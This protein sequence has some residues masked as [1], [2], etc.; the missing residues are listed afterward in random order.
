MFANRRRGNHRR[1]RSRREFSRCR[2]PLRP[3]PQSNVERRRRQVGRR[4]R[5]SL[6]FPL[7]H[8]QGEPRPPSVRATWYRLA[9]VGLGNGSGG[10]FDDQ[11]YVGV[12]TPWQWPDA[13]DGVTVSDLR[14]A[15]AAIA[16][17]R[18]REN[19][20]AKDWAG[21]AVAKAMGLDATNKAHRAKIPPC[22]GCG[23]RKE[24]WPSSRAWTPNARSGISSKWA[25]RPMTDFAAPAFRLSPCRAA[26]HT[27]IGG[28][29]AATGAP[30]LPH[31]A[32][33]HLCQVRQHRRRAKYRQTGQRSTMPLAGNNA[34]SSGP[35]LGLVSGRAAYFRA[36][37]SALGPHPGGDFRW[38]RR[39]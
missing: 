8:R 1:R 30:H 26:P 24:C 27:P 17:G 25:S 3:R 29:G 5:T 34:K 12:V 14:K 22:S 37:A 6:L 21:H 15:Q 36:R 7:R 23:S 13:F 32:V 28:G 20:Q 11:D 16:A 18:W 35:S 33:P 4:R 10:P 2:R 39:R 9:N 38:R 19:A 31:L